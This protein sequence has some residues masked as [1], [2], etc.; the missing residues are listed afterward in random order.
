MNE[1]LDLR[2]DTVTRPTQGMRRAIAEAVVGDDVFGDDPTVQRLEEL[3]A[4]L[5]GKQAAL[6]MASGTMSNQVA[7]ACL[8]RPGDEIILEESSH[9]YLYEAGGPA[10]ISGVQIR[11]VPG[12]RGLISAD[13]LRASLRPSDVHYPETKVLIFENTHNRSGGRVLPL[14]QMQETAAAAREA[15]LRI[16]L[17]GARLWNAAIASGVSE[18][19]YAAVCDTVSVCLS[20]GMGAPIGSILSA[21]AETIARARHVRKRLGGGMRQVGILAAAG[22][23]ALEHHRERLAED[24]RRAHTLAAGLAGIEGLRLDVDAT[25]TNIVI[26]ELERGNPQEWL[27]ELQQAGVL[28]V[29]F[30]RSALRAVTHLDIRDEDLTRAVEAFRVVAGRR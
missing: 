24:H 19:R 8:T 15:G 13:R 3:T 1:I 30:G 26:I 14:D 5:L 16:H 4:E 22:L 20:K 27:E 11:P 10:V 25:E 18:S 28:V 21:D 2:S 7:I 9:S 6:F 17:D 29:P 23:Y 12:D